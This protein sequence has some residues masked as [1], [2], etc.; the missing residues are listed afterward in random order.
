MARRVLGVRSPRHHDRSLYY[1][2]ATE[3]RH[4]LRAADGSI[5]LRAVQV[6]CGPAHWMVRPAEM[7]ITQESVKV[8]RRA[9]V[10]SVR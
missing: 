6:F 10:R 1:C 5:G 8:P 3:L 4:F 9:T 2:T 7:C